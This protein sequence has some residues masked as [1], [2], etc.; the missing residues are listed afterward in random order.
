MNL[1]IEEDFNSAL[2]SLKDFMK[3]LYITLFK[4]ELHQKIQIVW[5]VDMENI[6][7]GCSRSYKFMRGL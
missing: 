5:N 7:C 2:K 1:L 4:L 6:L 3:T